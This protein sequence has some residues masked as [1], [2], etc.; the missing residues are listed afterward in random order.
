MGLSGFE[1]ISGFCRM[2]WVQ[3]YLIHYY[4]AVQ[5]NKVSNSDD[6]FPYNSNGRS[7]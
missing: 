3:L 7:E 4:E 6:A 1:L 5:K 2:N